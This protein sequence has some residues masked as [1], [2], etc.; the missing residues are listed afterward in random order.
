MLTLKDGGHIALDWR[1]SDPKHVVV[2][3]H[4]LTVT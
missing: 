4:G 2:I 1:Y 3:A